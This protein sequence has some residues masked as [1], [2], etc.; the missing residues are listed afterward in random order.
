MASQTAAARGRRSSTKLSRTVSPFLSLITLSAETI[1]NLRV[2]WAQVAKVGKFWDPRYGHFELT[3][4]DLQTMLANFKTG[5]VGTDIPFDFNHGTSNADSSDA[6]KAAGWFKELELRADGTE[7]WARA[8]W[9]EAAAAMIEAQEYRYISPTFHYAFKPSEGDRRGQNVGTTLTA[10]AL[11]NTPVLDMAPLSLNREGTIQ[12]ADGGD[13]AATAIFSFD[14][15]RR[16]VQ[17]AVTENFA[18]YQDDIYGPCWGVYLA[19]FYTGWCVY[20]VYEGAHYR[21]D[22]SIGADGVVTFSSAPVEVVNDWRP[23]QETTMSRTAG[24]EN[25]TAPV[26][27]KDAD[28]KE[29][30]LSRETIAEIVRQAQPAGQVDLARQVNDLQTVVTSQGVTIT[31]LTNKNAELALARQKDSATAEVDALVRAGKILPVAREHYVELAMANRDLFV[32][33]TA[34]LPKLIDLNAEVGSGADAAAGGD[35]VN[36][37]PLEAAIAAERT[38]N[39]KLTREQAY[40]AALTKNPSLYNQDA[41]I[42]TGRAR[43]N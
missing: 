26:V 39:P 31:E 6:G 33:M 1:D 22:F 3:T 34:N 9:T 13:S 43:A 32:K 5:V 17:A 25:T 29:V 36:P 28:G 40:A 11:T 27:V 42:A 23:L 14:E 41:T 24:T 10:A 7:L 37:A 18:P 20:R 35:A 4:D 12:L 16:R 15:Q 19:D 21:V 38:A 8:G 2:G 30:K